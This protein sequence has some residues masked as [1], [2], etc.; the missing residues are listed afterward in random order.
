MTKFGSVDSTK[1]LFNEEQQE[2]VDGFTDKRLVDGRRLQMASFKFKA[3]KIRAAVTDN[4]K[5]RSN[6]D[7]I[8][9]D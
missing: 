2:E 6:Q 1:W 5:R 3:K 7:C 8:T 4:K 9:D